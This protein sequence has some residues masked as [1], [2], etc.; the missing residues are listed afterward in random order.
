MGVDPRT[1][2]FF[3]AITV[4]MQAMCLELDETDVASLYS[5]AEQ[6]LD[7]DDPAFR[8]IAGFCTQHMEVKY[9]SVRLPEAGREL[10]D[11]ITY[12]MRPAPPAPIDADRKDIHG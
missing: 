12:L 1:G 7:H 2:V 6:V 9:D 11:T 5:Q 4:G 10:R 8:A 3:N